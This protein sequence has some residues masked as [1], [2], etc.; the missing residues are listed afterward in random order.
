MA[1]S[2]AKV[3]MNLGVQ[4]EEVRRRVQVTFSENS[5]VSNC[6]E[7]ESDESNDEE[8]VNVPSHQ[9]GIPHQH[10]SLSSL[11]GEDFET[12]QMLDP[13]LIAFFEQQKYKQDEQKQ[14]RK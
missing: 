8:N 13:F 10:C 9:R 6:N 1:E 5:S 2:T 3:D 14:Q 11:V 4:A 7:D 12:E